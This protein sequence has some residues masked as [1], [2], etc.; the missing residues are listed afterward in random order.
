[1]FDKISKKSMKKLIGQYTRDPST[2]DLLNKLLMFNPEKIITI[3]EA[4]AHSYVRDFQNK[5]EEI[6]C[7]RKITIP[8]DD[9]QKF[10]LDQYRQK[11]YEEVLRRKIEIKKKLIESIKRNHV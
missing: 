6:A 9:T 8:M 2:F 3:E 5:D 11:L 10:T 4:I 7:E 1:M